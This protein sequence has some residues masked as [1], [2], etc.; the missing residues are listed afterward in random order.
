MTV[1]VTLANSVKL[2]A[3]Q[4]VSFTN[5]DILFD[6]YTSCGTSRKYNVPLP[7]IKSI[8]VDEP[9]YRILGTQE[10]IREFLGQYV[11]VP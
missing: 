4:I 7:Q 3:A 8:E 11:Y 9:I 10:E 5:E 2:V 1:E 6:C